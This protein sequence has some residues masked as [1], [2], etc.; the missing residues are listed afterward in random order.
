MGCKCMY[1][2]FVFYQQDGGGFGE[3]GDLFWFGFFGF[4]CFCFFDCWDMVWQEQLEDGFDIYFGGIENE[5]FCLFYDF[6]DGGQIKIGFFVYFFG[7]EEWIEDFFYD[8]GWN[9]VIG[10]FDFYKC[11]FVWWYVV[12]VFELGG[13]YFIDIV[14]LDC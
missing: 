11:I 3:I 5:V 2:F 1:C 7:G 14:C 4:W 13:F 12:G 8:I 10:V 9:V 6:V